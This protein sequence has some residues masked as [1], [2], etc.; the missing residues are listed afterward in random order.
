VKITALAIT[1]DSNI[2]Q[3]KNFPVTHELLA[4][5]SA[6]FSRSNLGIEDIHS[7]IDW[8]NVQCR[9]LQILEHDYPI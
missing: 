7:K 6:R 9:T 1:P 4:A 5:S 3:T 2:D 8:S